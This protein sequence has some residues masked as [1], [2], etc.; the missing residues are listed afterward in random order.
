MPTWKKIIFVNAVKTRM[1]Q[2]NRTAEDIIKEYTK[3]TDEEKTE[4]LA[5]INMK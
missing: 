4:I 1:E 3:L 5:T 2:E